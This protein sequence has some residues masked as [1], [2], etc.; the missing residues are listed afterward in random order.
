MSNIGGGARGRGRPRGDEAPKVRAQKAAQKCRNKR[1]EQVGKVVSLLLKFIGDPSLTTPRGRELL[2]SKAR[3]MSRGVGDKNALRPLR[4]AIDAMDDDLPDLTPDDDLP[5]GEELPDLTPD[6]E[7]PD[8]PPDPMAM[9]SMGSGEE[10]AA[11]GQ[12]FTPSAVPAA[13]GRSLR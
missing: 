6:G 2:L 10:M 12:V 4:D 5:D 8:M 1:K 3:E 13:A 9:P 11:A 7:L